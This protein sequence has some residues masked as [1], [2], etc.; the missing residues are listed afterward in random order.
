M[1]VRPD[2]IVRDKEAQRITGL[3]KTLRLQLE[4]EGKFPKRRRITLRVVG[5]SERE[6]LEW[7]DARLNG[8]NAA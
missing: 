4:A 7:V 2:R 5:Y 6:L 3:G 8:S 1:M